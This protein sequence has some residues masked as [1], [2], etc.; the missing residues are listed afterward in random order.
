MIEPPP[1]ATNGN[2]AETKEIGKGTQGLKRNNRSIGGRENGLLKKT[3]C[4]RKFKPTSH[5]RR[6]G[7]KRGMVETL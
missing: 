1:I 4:V 6:R 7:E 5:L 2:D 3:K